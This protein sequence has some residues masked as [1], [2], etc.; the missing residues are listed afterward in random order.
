MSYIGSFVDTLPR[1]YIIKAGSSE[2]VGLFSPVII[3]SSMIYLIPNTFSQY[4]YPTFSFAYGKGY[5]RLYFWKKMRLILFLSLLVGLVSAVVAYFLVDWL[6]L[7]V[8]KYAASSACIKMACW[9]FAFI[10]Y[11]I[12]SMLCS[13]SI[14]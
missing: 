11:K 7:L 8:P 14:P 3:L 13:I 5:D 10:G 9:G 12:G 4:L 6:L 1:L 2:M